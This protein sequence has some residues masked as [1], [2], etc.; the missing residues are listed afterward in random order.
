MRYTEYDLKDPAEAGSN[1]TLLTG[2]T[3]AD[4]QEFGSV[5]TSIL[6]SDNVQQELAQFLFLRIVNNNFDVSMGDDDVGYYGST[7]L[8]TKILEEL[9]I[10][11]PVRALQV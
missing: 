11:A 9:G 10:W 7:K 2:L 1:A 8:L 4:L 6:V 3:Y 5:V